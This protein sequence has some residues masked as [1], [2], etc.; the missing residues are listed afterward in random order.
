MSL[1]TLKN[2]H[3]V[4][5]IGDIEVRAL[6]GVDVNVEKNEYVSIMGP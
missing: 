1:L 6:N 5:K 3:R 4:Y 2:I